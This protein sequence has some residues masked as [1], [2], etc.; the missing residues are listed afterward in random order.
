MLINCTN[1]ADPNDTFVINPPM[2]LPKGTYISYHHRYYTVEEILYDDENG[3]VDY[4]VS[5]D[6]YDPKDIKGLEAK[7]LGLCRDKQKLEAVKYVKEAS[8][9]GLK[10]AKDFVDDLCEKYGI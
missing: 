8:H 2:V 9:V 10:D 4:K 3:C 1:I 5:L 7:V 6:R